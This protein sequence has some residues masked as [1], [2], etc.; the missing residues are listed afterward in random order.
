MSEEIKYK[1]LRNA[2]SVAF[3]IFCPGCQCGHAFY[4][5]KPSP[6]FCH[7]CMASWHPDFSAK[8]E[9]HLPGCTGRQLGGG[10]TWSFNRDM[11]KPTFRASMLVGM[12]RPGERCHSFV[13]DGN[14][15][16]LDD[17]DHALRGQTV[18]LEEF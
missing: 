7:G 9:F 16:F 4:V 14:I 15:Q 10:E 1:V 6:R 17:C 8:E 12:N 3:V 2:E 13:T 11:D 18:P 5:D